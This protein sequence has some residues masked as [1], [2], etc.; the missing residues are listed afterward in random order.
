MVKRLGLSLFK[1]LL[2]ILFTSINIECSVVI[3]LAK[4]CMSYVMWFQGR[5]VPKFLN[6]LMEVRPGCTEK[7]WSSVWASYL[8]VSSLPTCCA[9][10]CKAEI[11]RIG[12]LGKSYNFVP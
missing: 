12:D 7:H 4:I 10:V 3:Q 9:C 6:L 8:V 2:G 1:Y 11:Y 5:V